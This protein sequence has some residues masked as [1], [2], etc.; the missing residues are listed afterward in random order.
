M[1]REVAL[2]H[3]VGV[4][5]VGGRWV[6]GGTVLQVEALSGEVNWMG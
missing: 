5:D 3:A 2:N 6:E 4:R 1:E